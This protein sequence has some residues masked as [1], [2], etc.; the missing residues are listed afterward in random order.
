MDLIQSLC[1]D[2]R[3]DQ[4]L[5]SPAIDQVVE[6]DAP[7]TGEASCALSDISERMSDYNRYTPDETVP[8]VEEE[9]EE[10]EE[11]DDD[12]IPIEIRDSIRKSAEEIFL[13]EEAIKDSHLVPCLE[14]YQRHNFICQQLRD[15][16]GEVNGD[17]YG[18]EEI[19]C[20]LELMEH[21]INEEE[22]ALGMLEQALAAA[23][24]L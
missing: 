4:P 15:A 12:H 10:E 7:P 22:E 8:S 13:S 23:P 1:E 17:T 11:E 19:S 6:Y 16:V 2:S 9:E 21:L 24:G 20:Y 3:L 14:N 5:N 18:E